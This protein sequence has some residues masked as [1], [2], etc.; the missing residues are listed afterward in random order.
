MKFGE[1][2]FNWVNRKFVELYW[3]L[4]KLIVNFGM[5]LKL[6]YVRGKLREMDLNWVKLLGNLGN[7]IDIELSW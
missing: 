7:L 4:I 5:W 1:L 2:D 6:R 3:N